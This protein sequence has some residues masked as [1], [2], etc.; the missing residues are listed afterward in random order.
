MFLPIRDP[1]LPKPRPGPPTRMGHFGE[2]ATRTS[3]QDGAFWRNRDPDL[4]KSATRTS[5][6]AEVFH[7]EAATGA[8][9]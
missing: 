2:T 1:D 7:R 6:L 5:H 9:A 4:P 8:V 3:H